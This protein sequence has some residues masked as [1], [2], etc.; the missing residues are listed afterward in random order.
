LGAVYSFWL[1]NRLCFQTIQFNYLKNFNDLSLREFFI[2]FIFAILIL[3]FGIYPDIILRYLEL[4]LY[5]FFSLR[6]FHYNLIF[7]L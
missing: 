3:L 4:P 6:F 1:F 2:L 5:N 7:Y